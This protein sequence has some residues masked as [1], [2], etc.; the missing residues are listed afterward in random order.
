MPFIVI[1]ELSIRDDKVKLV[2][3]LYKQNKNI[4]EIAKEVHISFSDIGT[5]FKKE[6]GT[7]GDDESFEVKAFELFSKGLKPL[8]VIMKLNMKADEV[9]KLYTEYQ[10]LSGLGKLNTMYEELGEN[11]EQ[12]FQLY[13]I[14]REQGFGAEE[15]VKAIKYG[16]DLP[17]LGLK[18]ESVKEQLKLTEDKKQNLISEQQDLDNATA[19]SRTI[20]ANLDHGIQKR[21]NAVKS[22]ECKERNLI[23]R[24]LNLMHTK[25]YKKVEEI[26][27]CETRTILNDRK[28]VL[29][30]I[31]FALI[32]AFRLNPEKQILISAA[33][34]NEYQR[35]ELLELA[36]NIL[37][38]LTEELV[39][40]T[41]DS[42]FG[43]KQTIVS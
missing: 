15:I 13:K 14:M 26:A 28:T 12:F 9:K 3:E 32:Q 8:D 19:V 17:L 22:L 6:F 11:I 23:D 31:L 30:L 35:S 29:K 24:I 43:Q 41:M 42:V 33:T 38:M 10:G 34:N 25:E 21:T 1:K 20:I 5:I 2:I 36:E 18:Y 7:N 39:K 37:D 27:R 16:N 40:G 4:R